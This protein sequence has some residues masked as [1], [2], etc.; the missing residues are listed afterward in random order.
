[1]YCKYCGKEVN[2]RAELCVHCGRRI[3]SSFASLKD[4]EFLALRPQ[5]TTKSPG[6]AGFLGFSLGWLFLGPIGY[7]YLGQRNWFWV[8][9]GV[10][11]LAFLITFGLAYILL[12]FV[13][14]F[15]QYQMAQELNSLQDASDGAGGGVENPPATPV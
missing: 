3:R 2:E 10:S 8:T 6:L 11:L 12:P 5:K 9:A 15:H 13:F 14:A 4:S 7:A 1:M